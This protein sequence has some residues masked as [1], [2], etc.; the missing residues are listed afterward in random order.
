[1]RSLSLLLVPLALATALAQE[2]R[3]K[4]GILLTRG[5]SLC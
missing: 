1:M 5:G 3:G 4:G 2:P